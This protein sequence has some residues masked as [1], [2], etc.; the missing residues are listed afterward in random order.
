MTLLKRRF[1]ISE[2]QSQKCYNRDKIEIISASDEASFSA[3][4]ASVARWA[5]LIE[6]VK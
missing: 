3:T 5:L 4:A 2:M 6:R 1:F